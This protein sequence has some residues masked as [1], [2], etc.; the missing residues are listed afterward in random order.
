MFVEEFQILWDFSQLPKLQ[1]EKPL[2]HTIHEWYDKCIFHSSIQIHFK[3][4]AE[5][6]FSFKWIDRIVKILIIQGP[7]L[8]IE[9]FCL[10]TEINTAPAG[11]SF[12]VTYAEILPI[13]WRNS[14]RFLRHG[15]HYYTW[16]LLPIKIS[17]KSNEANLNYWILK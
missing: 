13:Y 6:L 2:E 1:F 4:A 9:F 11:S 17:S 8:T 15:A 3:N 5:W 14:G 10:I 12:Q 7:F 16:D